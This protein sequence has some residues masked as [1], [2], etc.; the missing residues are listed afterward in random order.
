MKSRTL[1]ALILFL[2]A[3]LLWGCSDG[4]ESPLAPGVSQET[5][6]APRHQTATHL[7]GYYDVSVDVEKMEAVPILNR[8]A[9]FTANCVNFLNSVAPGVSF[10]IYNVETTPDYVDVDLIVSLKHPFP[11]MDQYDGYD[12]RGVFM[13]DGSGIMAYNSELLYPIVGQDQS[14]E[15]DLT[16]PSGAN[17]HPDGYTRWFNISEFG[18]PGMPLFLYTKGKYA[19]SDFHGTATLCPYKYFADGLGENEGLTD[20]LK[21]NPPTHGVFSAGS[22][23][24]RDYKM[25]FPSGKP[26]EYGYAVVANWNGPNPEDHPA[27]APEA[28]GCRAD[29]GGT[30]Y[31]VDPTDFGGD[32]DLTLD[33][34]DWGDHQLSGAM[35]D[36]Q[37]YLESTA[38]SS[39]YEFT[40]S[41]MT[42][43]GGGL[44]YSTYEVEIAA[45]NLAGAEGNEYWVIVECADADYSNEFGVMNDAWDDP[46]AAFF[47]FDLKVSNISPNE[48]P[49]CDLQVNEC[50]VDYWDITDH[51]AVEFDASGSYD[52]EGGPLAYEWDFDNDGIYG[53]AGDDDY[54]GSPDKPSHVYY[55][56]GTCN[57]RVTDQE[58][59][60]S[61][62]STQVDITEHPSKNIPLREAPWEARD[63]AV[64][65]ANGD[66]H[67]LYYWHEIVIPN[68]EEYYWIETWKYSP[69][70][71]YPEP[72]EAFHVQPEG[73][74]FHRIDVSATHYSVIGGPGQ[75]FSGRVRNITPDGVDI[76]PN[77]V[78]NCTELWAFNGGGNWAYDHCTI[79]PF[80]SPP[81]NPSGYSTFLYR[82]PDNTTFDTWH[83]S[84]LIYWNYQPTGYDVLY[85]GTLRGLEPSKTGDTFWCVKDPGD[86]GVNDYYGNRWRLDQSPGGLS[87]VNFD[88]VWFGTG[89]QTESDDGW[90]NAQDLTRNVDDDLM[91]L[92][93]MP[94]GHGRVKGFKGDASGGSSL[95]GFDIPSDVSATPIRIDSSDYLDPIYGNL[96]YI[97]H[98]NPADG[99]LLSIYF[100]E[101]LP[102]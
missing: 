35:Q 27:N 17:G 48:L 87:G 45:D 53:E 10:Q 74:M 63:L 36:Y 62:C 73:R 14:F 97:L 11:G 54:T 100:P 69:C 31:Y 90:F 93:K 96:V 4:R 24:K 25:R 88:N 3:A 71:C 91:V 84:A 55:V 65:P 102:W 52:P 77:W 51:V 79:Y 9:M 18:G 66:L 80:P 101:E 92:D 43:V 86:A 76:G 50:T 8:S 99:F 60:S 2:L 47:R 41:Q 21:N 22:V 67:V 57:L 28:I 37:I 29:Q 26:V 64:D 23:N 83:Q 42:P 32:I 5:F 1:I 12:V 7:W 49:V 15:P 81:W 19:S 56:D 72:E 40:E 94:D 75:G 13:A 85:A 98:G 39:V 78:I 16:D 44:N 6:A 59:D 61:E 58:N 95:G 70:G 33:I 38:L 46:L 89:S 82:S 34:F 30:V 20:W 68:V